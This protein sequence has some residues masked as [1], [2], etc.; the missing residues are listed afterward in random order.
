HYHFPLLTLAFIALVYVRG[1]RWRAHLPRLALFLVASLVV[2]MLFIDRSWDGNWYH[3]RAIIALADGWNPVYQI[4]GIEN[5][6]WP[7]VYWKSTW[8]LGGLAYETIPLMNIV[9]F[10]NWTLITAVFFTSRASL[11]TVG[12]SRGWANLIAAAIALNPVS[13]L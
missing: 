13:S 4:L 1:R 8:V 6:P 5:L 2:S 12:L 7:D 3:K 9:A 11:A 10:V